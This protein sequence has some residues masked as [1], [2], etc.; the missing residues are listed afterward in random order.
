MDESDLLPIFHVLIYM[1][2]LQPGDLEC[3]R[4]QSDVDH[5]IELGYPTANPKK[6]ELVVNGKTSS[7]P[8]QQVVECRSTMAVCHL[9]CGPGPCFSTGGN[10]Q[11]VIATLGEPALSNSILCDQFSACLLLQHLSCSRML[12]LFPISLVLTLAILAATVTQ[13]NHWSSHL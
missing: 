11:G 6:L 8:L 13:L 3:Q 5:A 10:S 4:D 9:C 7:F 1:F 12:Q 2:V